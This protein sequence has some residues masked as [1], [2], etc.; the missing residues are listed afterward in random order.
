ME[1]LTAINILSVF[2]LEGYSI[3]TGENL[4]IDDVKITA[5]RF[6]E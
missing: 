2:K 3:D 1:L 4:W 6:T 5:S